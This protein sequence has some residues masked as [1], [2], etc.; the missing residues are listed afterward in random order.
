MEYA[1]AYSKMVADAMK[2]S[3][4][5]ML[6]EA[7]MVAD[8]VRGAILNALGGMKYPRKIRLPK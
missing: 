5:P 3:R 7:D 8:I 2:A 1:E 6:V 4:S